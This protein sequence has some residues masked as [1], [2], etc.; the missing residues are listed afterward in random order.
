M[1]AV[2]AI[3]RIVKHKVG[4]GTGVGGE[5]RGKV[6]GDGARP[7]TLAKP[8][9]PPEPHHRHHH[10]AR[11]FQVRRQ[12]ILRREMEFL[13]RATHP[14][15]INVVDLIEDPTRLWIVQ[16][17]GEVGEVLGGVWR[18]GRCWAAVSCQL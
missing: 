13:L 6:G 12:H 8:H 11:R 1:C 9:T 17:R 2:F 16:V 15:I 5:G 14:N 7:A 18:W 4:G 10:H 3:K